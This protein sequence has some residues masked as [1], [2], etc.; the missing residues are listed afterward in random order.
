MKSYPAPIA[1]ERVLEEI[2]RLSYELAETIPPWFVQPFDIPAHGVD[3]KAFIGEQG[4]QMD[5]VNGRLCST[6]VEI[7]GG[8]HLFD[9]KRFKEDRGSPEAFLSLVKEQLEGAKNG[10]L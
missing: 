5:Y 3:F 4:L 1:A 10:R 9:A 7:R 6:Y 2:A 8:K